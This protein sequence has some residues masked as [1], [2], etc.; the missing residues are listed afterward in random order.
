MAK[1]DKAIPEEIPIEEAPAVIQELVAA[2]AEETV[3][4]RE[5]RLKR[6][7]YQKRNL[8]AIAEREEILRRNGVIGP[9][10]RL[11]MDTEAAIRAR[12]CF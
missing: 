8:A 12:C 7:D 9:G 5:A 3:E 10:E 1:T 6:E 11:T 2:Q 4:E